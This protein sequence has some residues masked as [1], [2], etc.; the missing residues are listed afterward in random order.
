MLLVN[1]RDENNTFKYCIFIF[2][3]NY[4]LLKQC[5]VL[6]DNKYIENLDQKIEYVFS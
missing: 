4:K 6:T 2:D 1:F 3:T 5:D